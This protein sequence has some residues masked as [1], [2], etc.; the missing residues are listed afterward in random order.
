MLLLVLSLASCVYPEDKPQVEYSDLLAF[1]PSRDTPALV[2]QGEYDD[3]YIEFLRNDKIY[4]SWKN[5]L[6]GEIISFE[7]VEFNEK[8]TETYLKSNNQISG[9]IFISPNDFMVQASD[10]AN[11]MYFHIIDLNENILIMQVEMQGT[12]YIS[13]WERQ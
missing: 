9:I 7:K 1:G 10:E 4:G 12:L 8:E 2:I 3:Y 11:N 6:S 5:T 13:V